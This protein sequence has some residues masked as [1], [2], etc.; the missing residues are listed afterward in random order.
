[1]Y[2]VNIMF[3]QT[4][5]SIDDI[6]LR[7]AGCTSELDYAEQFSWLMFLKYIDALEVDKAQEAQENKKSY[8]FIIEKTYRWET[9]AVPKGK[10][11]NS[12][13]SATKTGKDLND[14]VNYQL[15]PY[16][17]E[18]KQHSVAPESIEYKI[19]EIFAE[20]KNRIQS[21]DNLREV[22]ELIDKLRFKSQ[23]D[24]Q[25]LAKLYEAKIKNMGNAGR[26]GGEHY[27][28]R[29]L[30][31]AMIQVVAP[32]IGERV[33]DGACGSSGFLCETFDYINKQ[34]K[35]SATNQKL[36]QSNTLF[37]KEKMSLAFVIGIINMILHGIEK[38]SVL[39][40]NT[41]AENIADVKDADQFDVILSNPPIGG[42]ERKE[43]QK[44]FPIK[45]AETAF[46]FVQHFFKSL[47]TGG[48][49]A[50]VIKNTFLTNSDKASVSL[51]KL[52]LESCNLH[53]ILDCPSGT[54]N[55]AGVKT[56]V[57]F[58][59]KGRPTR[60]IWIYQLDVGRNMGKTNPLTDADLIPFTVAQ[61]TF[62]DTAQS[63]SLDIDDLK[64]NSYEISVKKPGFIEAVEHR[65]PKYI[66][67]EIIALDSEAAEVL[68]ALRE[69]L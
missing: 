38:P 40:T 65:S 25:E 42:K 7:D 5:R 63:W 43:L 62:A 60:K 32:K 11:G 24:R 27:T 4:F 28:P 19:G 47:R 26:T 61:R 10:D 13:R 66:M 68:L 37:G 48:R 6:L 41:L 30:I 31:R 21:G 8:K 55:G 14:F 1:M 20:T 12:D 23:H 58:F 54:F 16:M 57:L 64:T 36:L 53:T 69:M 39:H 67:D 29:P 33:Y 3:E 34:T 35:L 51:R 45:T 49:A 15:I 56:V 50:I 17:H 2:G 44:N 46:L 22:I 59:D 52:L 9:W 18:F